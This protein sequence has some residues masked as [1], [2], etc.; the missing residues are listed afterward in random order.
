MILHLEVSLW[1]FITWLHEFM[2][3]QQV[4]KIR[5]CCFLG[6]FPSSQL[7]LAWSLRSHHLQLARTILYIKLAYTVFDNF[8]F[9]YKW[10]YW[11]LN[12]MYIWYFNL[13]VRGMV[14][15]FYKD[16]LV[17]CSYWQDL[18]YLANFTRPGV[19]NMPVY[20]VKT[21]VYCAIS[22]LWI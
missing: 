17:F 7:Q 4:L 10:N 19:A 1:S 22:A 5:I 14:N 11:R 21:S 2:S 16:S 20:A 3:I 13:A 6:F 12:D 9:W 8:L 18:S 15:I